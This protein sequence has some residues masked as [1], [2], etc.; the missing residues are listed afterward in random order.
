MG[1]GSATAAAMQI[2]STFRSIRL[3]LMV[4]IGD[5]VPGGDANIRLGDVVV[6]HPEKSRGVVQYEFGK[7]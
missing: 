2:G 1:I 3:G 5:D 7:T 4:A 6:R